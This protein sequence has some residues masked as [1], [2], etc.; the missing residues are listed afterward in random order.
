MGSM[1][2]HTDVLSIILWA[3]VVIVAW[4]LRGSYREMSEKLGKL[5]TCILDV[6]KGYVKKADLDDCRIACKHNRHEC[7]A[8]SKDSSDRILRVLE[9][10]ERNVDR[11]H[12]LIFHLCDKLV[13]KGSL[14][15]EDLSDLR[16]KKEAE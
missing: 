13:D 9:R 2:E 5:E 16:D 4:F 8:L 11:N 14:K 12:S 1:A 10:L 6:K 15:G 3:A 7:R